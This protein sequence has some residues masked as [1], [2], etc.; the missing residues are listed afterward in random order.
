MEMLL[1]AISLAVAAIPEGLPAVVTIVL[2]LGVQKMVKVHTIVRKLPAVETLGAVS[3]VC[4]DKTG[5][6]TQNKMTVTKVYADESLRNVS[7]LRY[8]TDELF[9]SGFILCTDA[10][11]GGDTRIGDPTELA[12][13]DMGLSL[14]IDKETL[15]KSQPRINELAFDS[16]RKMMT[17]VHQLADGRIIA[18]T[19][20]AMDRIIEN[21]DFDRDQR[22][23]STDHSRRQVERPGRGKRKWLLW[24][25]AYLPWQ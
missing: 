20:G 10:T 11:A 22:Q 21:C 13:I 1:T 4:S 19:K 3:I 7:E 16:D 6:L 5:T 24:R 14:G 25:C 9:I 17:T 15:E 18:Y 8:D 2:A 23:H 12:L